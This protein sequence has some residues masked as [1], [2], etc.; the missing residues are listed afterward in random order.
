VIV[1]NDFLDKDEIKEKGLSA[2]QKI[3]AEEA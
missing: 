1:I 3:T 2:V